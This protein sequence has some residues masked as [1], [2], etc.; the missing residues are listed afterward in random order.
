MSGFCS[1]G[2]HG[3]AVFH[4]SIAGACWVTDR[5]DGVSNG[6]LSEGTQ[7]LPVNFFQ[8]T[9]IQFP[10]VWKY[11]TC[12]TRLFDNMETLTVTHLYNGNVR[13][14]NM[15]NN[16]SVCCPANTFLL[17]AIIP[18]ISMNMHKI[19]ENVLPRVCCNLL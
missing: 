15:E 18:F 10:K 7:G 11:K 2:L 14:S 16:L 19:I 12:S 4:C 6:S 9:F 17:C 5:W 8:L 1:I 13:Y 3:E